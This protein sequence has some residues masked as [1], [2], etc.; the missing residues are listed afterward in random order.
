MLFC[1]NVI[2]SECSILAMKIFQGVPD[3]LASARRC[4]YS[5]KTSNFHYREP[6]RVF[7]DKAALALSCYMIS[8]NCRILDTSWYCVN[9]KP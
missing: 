6:H 3:Y 1:D 2:A 7:S 9:V 5:A 8:L 4:L